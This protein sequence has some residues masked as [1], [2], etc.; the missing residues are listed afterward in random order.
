MVVKAISY[1]H[2][3]NLWRQTMKGTI[4]FAPKNIKEFNGKKNISFKLE[5]N[6]EWFNLYHTEEELKKF[7]EVMTKG[8]EIE[9]EV[10][11]RNSV[12]NLNVTKLVPR[13]ESRPSSSHG[14]NWSDDY[15]NFEDLLDAAHEG[16]LKSVATEIIHYDFEKKTAVAKATV[17]MV[18]PDNKEIVRTFEAHGDASPDN[19]TDMIQPHFI[20]MAETRAFARALRFATNNAK[21]AVEELGE[22]SETMGM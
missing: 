2:Q 10:D 18:H 1:T 3:L 17:T 9:F 12:A 4:L 16:G 13:H 15:S 5:D 20:R 14:S 21:I 6:A 19:L 8:S 7:L 22:Q 11:E